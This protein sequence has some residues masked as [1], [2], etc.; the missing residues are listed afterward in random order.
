[1]SLAETI[2]NDLKTA[3]RE[4]DQT[5][6]GALRMLKADIRNREIDVGHELDDEEIQAVVRSMLKKRRESIDAYRE[7]GRDDLADNEA[8]EAEIL[9][10]YLPPELDDD[11]IVAIIDEV[12]GAAGEAPA[13]GPLMG[14]VMKR[15]GGQADGARVRA[16]LQQRL[17]ANG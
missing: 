14:Q 17:D 12:L 13:F 2:Q 9:Q 5:R 6:L 8:A 15:V 3:M 4:R 1:M 11:A 10:A 7:A 16:L